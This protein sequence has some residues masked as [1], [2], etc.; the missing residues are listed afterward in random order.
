MQHIQS[1]QLFENVKR[2]AELDNIAI[3]VINY[4]SQQTS[5]SFNKYVQ[6]IKKSYL[7]DEINFKLYND[8]KPNPINLSSL[9]YLKILKKND[10][11]KEMINFIKTYDLEIYY[12]HQY[13]KSS[14]VFKQDERRVVVF[15]PKDDVDEFDEDIKDNINDTTVYH[16]IKKMLKKH[17]DTLVHELQ[18]AWDFWVSNGKYV[19]KNIRLAHNKMNTE[20]DYSHYFKLSHEI[21]ARY[22]ETVHRLKNDGLKIKNSYG[23]HPYTVSLNWENLLRAFKDN[24]L[25]WN[26]IKPEQQ[27]RLIK[28][29]ATEYADMIKHKTPSNNIS[30]L[31]KEK[32]K[33]FEAQGAEITLHYI[34]DHD[35]I[36]VYAFLAKN[37]KQEREIMESLVKIAETHRKV[38]TLSPSK[39]YTGIKLT[40]FVPMLKDLGFVGNGGK[41]GTKKDFKFMDNMIRKPKREYK[42]IKQQEPILL[43]K[44][45]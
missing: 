22:A 2:Q 41:F 27:E 5:I 23:G 9:L 11:S 43:K 10:Y 39:G 4:L 15:I 24:F 34:H 44:V 20:N 7:E 19:D 38:I 25:G 16:G 1:F 14:G 36:R 18:H 8:L 12:T 29:L 26:L 40:T 21:N 17:I 32:E 3:A 6:E 33:E 45:A 42:S 31:I 37:E 13:G 30:K 28:R 35:Q